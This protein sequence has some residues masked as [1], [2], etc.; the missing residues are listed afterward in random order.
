MK[1]LIDHSLLAALTFIIGIA[2][3]RTAHAARP[4]ADPE[5]TVSPLATDLQALLLEANTLNTRFAAVSMSADSFCSELVN[6][7]Q[8]A[9]DHIDSI[10]NLN[11]ALSAPLTVDADV[12][13]AL[14]DLSAVYLSLGSEVV[15]FSTDLDTLNRSLD[16][17][18][19]A[20]GISTVLR[21]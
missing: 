21:L 17:L 3:T 6:A 18:S 1:A 14:E 8:A 5:P 16:Q 4:V 9:S 13:Q 15:S 2:L 7:N 12:L 19:I 20:Q 10:E 11:S